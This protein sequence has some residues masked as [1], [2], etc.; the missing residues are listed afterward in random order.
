MTTAMSRRLLRPALLAGLLSL[1]LIPVAVAPAGAADAVGVFDGDPATTERLNEGHPT[2]AAVDI[3]RVR[4]PVNGSAAHVVL[5]RDDSFA[6]SVAGSGLTGDGPLLFTETDR[7]SAPTAEEIDRVLDA[8]DTVYLLGGIAAISTAVAIELSDAGYEVGRLAGAS[9]I[10]TAI[11]VA[12]EVRRLHPGDEVLLARSDGWADSVT[13]GGVAAARNIPVLVTPPASLHPAVAAWIAEDAP[14]TTTL[15]GGTA[16]LSTSV[17]QSVPN[18]RRVSGIDRTATATAIADTLWDG[19]DA[20]YI[21]TQGLADDSWTF[22]FASA[23]LAA[24]ADAPILLVTDEV[25]DATAD[26]VSTCGEPSVD[27]AVVGDG[28]VVPA[29][30]REQ[31]D[32]AD[33]YACGPDGA[34]V[35]PTDLTTFPE[36]AALLSW[37]KQAALERVGPYGLGGFG[38]Y[39]RGDEVMPVEESVDSDD[40][41]SPA[42]TSDLANDAS[43]TNVQE[44]GVDEP[45]IVKTNGSVAYI[46]AQSELQVVRLDSGTPSVIASVPLAT[47]ASHELL[48][49]GSRL[50]V[51]SRTFSFIAFDDG[52]GDGVTDDALISPGGGTG[53]TKTMLTYYDVSNPAA[54]TATSTLEVDGDYRSA[55]MIGSVARIVVQTDPSA[56]AFTYPSDATPEAEQQAAEANRSMI[57][58]TTLD[59][60]L[61]SYSVNGGSDAALLDC[62]DVRQPPLFSGL[63][64]LSVLTVDVATGVTPTSTSALV[65]SGETVYASANRLYVTTGRWD[66]DPN[67][68]DS[69]VTTEV[70]GFDISS[71]TATSYV[72]SGAVE[73][74]IL[75]SFAL[76]EH[77][78]NLRIATTT[79]PPW[80]PDTGEQVGQ[81]ESIVTVLAEQGGNLTSIGRL[82]GLGLDERIY[83]VR[84][85]GDIG[86]VVTFRQVDPLY[87]LDL[88]EPTN[89]RVTGELKIPGFSA[90]LHRVDDTHLL[91]V[92]SEA[93]EEGRVTGAAVSLFDISNVTSPTLVDK[94][95][96]PGGH[97]QVQ[98]D[99]HAFLH[100]PATGLAVLPLE[101]YEEDGSGFMG[102]VGMVISGGDI[103][104]DRRATHVDD[105]G[106]DGAWPAITRSFVAGGALYTV[107]EAGVE[108]ADLS[109]LA[110]QAFVAF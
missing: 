63:G 105:V 82:A 84:W 76:S 79:S 14:A 107:S 40:G 13:G 106:T 104:S 19:D 78:G 6:D 54:P 56:L 35:Y 45:D 102:A 81:S 29:P 27:L 48:L 30:L 41:A 24:D 2:F 32:A 87:L 7:L 95:V 64:T 71:P 39:G 18:P 86:A 42:P 100:W 59:D 90:Y 52:I 60:W 85:F 17:E 1:P 20:K 57:E 61:P 26:A 98:Y 8:G 43:G 103:G 44:E 101:E 16:A 5:A 89:P 10:G 73:G 53:Q 80:S 55:R 33:G 31:L 9:R 69:T 66:W 25:T 22:G 70:H 28:A 23:G 3:S 47:D 83:A 110:E 108:K 88:S 77:E 65:A 93:D 99:H 92:G 96:F 12:D 68:L 38:S 46:V 109:T 75:N 49:S 50:L 67:A 11:A 58:D 97:T 51:V 15:L 34:L 21:V 36:C 94:V 4:F 91:G 74:Y 72:G 62:S 37:F